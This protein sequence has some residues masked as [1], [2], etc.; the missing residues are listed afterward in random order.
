MP[1]SWDF[2]SLVPLHPAFWDQWAGLY[3]DPVT[4]QLGPWAS[5]IWYLRR[6]FSMFPLWHSQ[7]PPT[8]MPRGSTPR[9]SQELT[10]APPETTAIAAGQQ[11][12]PALGTWPLSPPYCN[13]MRWGLL[14]SHFQ[15]VK[16]AQEVKRFAQINRSQA[17]KP[18]LT[19]TTVS[20]PTTTTL[21]PHR[22]IAVAYH[23]PFLVYWAVISPLN[24]PSAL[25]SGAW[26][27]QAGV[28]PEPVPLM[29]PH[30]CK[31]PEP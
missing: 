22:P 29:G 25:R 4:H 14:L 5:H 15:M 28:I 7:C 18:G 17:V 1:P 31:S 19:P 12:G 20:L 21:A 26:A 27:E 11:H 8:S 16:Q 2:P 13:S 30:G 3:L 9:A 24:K 10:R 6:S 23:L